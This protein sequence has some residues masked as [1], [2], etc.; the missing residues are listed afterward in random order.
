[1]MDDNVYRRAAMIVSS[2]D[3]QAADEVLDRLPPEQSQAIR[4][5][6]IALDECDHAERDRAIDDFL[7]T[8]ER[9]EFTTLAIDFNDDL[10]P[11][12]AAA[13]SRPESPRPAS[14][15]QD[16]LRQS[17]ET[18]AAAL[19]HERASVGAALLNA[20]PGRRAASILGR[21]PV[22]Q[23]SRI[24]AVLNLGVSARPEVLEVV[25]DAI[26]DKQAQLATSDKLGMHHHDALQ[27]I[28]D[29]LSPEERARMLD[30]LE[31]EN[32]LLAQRLR[33]SQAKGATDC[34]C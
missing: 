12:A 16:L 24:V 4:R 15:L 8:A 17:D 5:E 13:P 2:L 6:L 11:K 1:M 26:C 28:F 21:L 25:A 32:P 19:V 14:S 22:K 30:D 33:A 34:Y 20:I 23:Q 3:R 29:Q 18:I 27:A 10:S 9:E 31:H 7:R